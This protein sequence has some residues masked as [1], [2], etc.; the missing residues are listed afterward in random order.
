MLYFRDELIDGSRRMQLLC[1]LD[2]EPKMRVIVDRI[3]AARTL[4]AL[5][6]ARAYKRFA[7]PR[8]NTRALQA[9]FNCNL[10]EIPTSRQV[11]DVG[12]PRHP[13]PSATLARA[14]SVPVHR[15]VYEKAQAACKE[16]GVSMS[17]MLRYYIHELA[18]ET[19]PHPVLLQQKGAAE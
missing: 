4:W 1:L 18:G 7:D 12:R 10:S 16:H 14:P 5:H 2:I 11:Q 6:P 8:S 19:A 13:V 15:R 9:L 3:E 17:A